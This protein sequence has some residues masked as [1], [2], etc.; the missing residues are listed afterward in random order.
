MDIEYI[1][2]LICHN[3]TLNM[4]LLSPLHQTGL[5]KIFKFLKL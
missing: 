2:C 3:L 1:L 4:I 5:Y